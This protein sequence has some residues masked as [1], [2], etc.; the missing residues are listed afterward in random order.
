MPKIWV[1]YLWE[2]GTFQ[3]IMV[4]QQCKEMSHNEEKKA[5]CCNFSYL[6]VGQSKSKGNTAASIGLIEYGEPGH[7]G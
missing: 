1:G 7:I 4:K 3:D 6:L 2:W 5:E